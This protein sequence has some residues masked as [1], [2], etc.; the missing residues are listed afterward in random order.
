MK[1]AELA[2]Y[3]KDAVDYDFYTNDFPVK[4]K[5]NCGFVLLDGGESPNVYIPTM[6]S[7]GF[8][9]MIRHK[10]QA[11]GEL[12]ANEVW[13]L[14]HG[15]DHYEIGSDHVYVSMCRQSEPIYI[16]E[17]KN[18]RSLF[19]INVTCRNRQRLN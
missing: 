17:D 7:T 19:S 14:F 12:I 6:K 18:G 5:D 4:A 9:V 3:I 13:V 1:V 2:N 15:K 11:V 16:G 8:Q 10:D